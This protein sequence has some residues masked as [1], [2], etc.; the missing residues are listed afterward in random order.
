LIAIDVH[1]T[2]NSEFGESLGNVLLRDLI[3]VIVGGCRRNP[4]YRSAAGAA[5]SVVLKFRRRM[6]HPPDPVDKGE[7]GQTIADRGTAG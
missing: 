4:S 2:A 7:C 6:T 1:T 5:A 3:T